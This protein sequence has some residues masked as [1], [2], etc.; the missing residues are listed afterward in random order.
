MHVVAATIVNNIFYGFKYSYFK[1]DR[2]SPNK[3]EYFSFAVTGF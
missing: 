1:A 2:E 3:Y